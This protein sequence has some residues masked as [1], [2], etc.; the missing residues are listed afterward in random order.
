MDNHFRLLGLP[1][2]CD[3]VALKKAYR[4]KALALHPDRNPGGAELFKKVNE[5]Y[6]AL[7]LHF[8]RNGGRDSAPAPTAA[9]AG[10]AASSSF[11]FSAFCAN[12]GTGF[13]YARGARDAPEPRRFFTDEELFG[14]VPGGFTYEKRFPGAGAAKA[15]RGSSAF[16]SQ[17]HERWRRAHGDRVPVSGYSTH[18]GTPPPAPPMYQHQRQQQQQQQSSN[19]RASPNRSSF[20]GDL[21]SGRQSFPKENMNRREN[22]MNERPSA[23]PKPQRTSV[24]MEDD[25]PGH[26]NS[27]GKKSNGKRVFTSANPEDSTF[28]SA[29]T[30]SLSDMLDDFEIQETLCRVRREWEKLK[31]DLDHKMSQTVPQPSRPHNSR[32]GRG[33]DDGE[34]DYVVHP[35]PP[36]SSESDVFLQRLRERQRLNDNHMRSILE[37]KLRLK[38]VLFMQRYAPDPADVALMSDSEVFVI[39]EL[40]RDVGERMKKVLNARLTKGLCSRCSTAPKWQNNRIF[41]CGH[42]S[43]CEECA[44]SSGMCPVC[45]A[46]RR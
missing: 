17:A 30:S 35:K 16:H 46:S 14:D 45:A 33:T 10:S 19:A 29:R 11:A 4:Q 20:T 28:S 38:K 22:T 44:V 8:R 27:Q 18:S 36:S 41:Q 3:E 9:G 26:C 2:G 34:E 6:E 40:L 31:S 7:S 12:A 21:H 23:D 15:G 39:C 24:Y 13:H 37:E 25:S 32:R 42:T 5:A 1:R 43:V